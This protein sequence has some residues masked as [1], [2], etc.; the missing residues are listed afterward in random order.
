MARFAAFRARNRGVLIPF[1]E[2]DDPDLANAEAILRG[3]PA[4]GADLI[5]IGVPFTDPTADGPIIQ[6]T[7]KCRPA[8]DATPGRTLEMAARF[9][10]A[11]GAVGMNGLPVS[12]RLRHR[13]SDPAGVRIA[14]RRRRRG[15]SLIDTLAHSLDEQGRAGPDTVRLV[16]GQAGPLADGVR[17]AR[18]MEIVA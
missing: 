4:M 8:A 9:R 5:E 16:S 7:S 15:A 11:D 17:D 13:H 1:L 14:D 18:M 3:M 6:A 10:I 2:T 12:D